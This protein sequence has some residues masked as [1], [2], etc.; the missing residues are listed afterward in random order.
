MK[1][2]NARR[3]FVTQYVQNGGTE[4]QLRKIVGHAGQQMTDHYTVQREDMSGLAE[5]VNI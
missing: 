5:I 3:F 4:V 1:F 2:H